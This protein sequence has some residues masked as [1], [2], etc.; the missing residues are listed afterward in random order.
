MAGKTA[1]SPYEALKQSLGD[2]PWYIAGDVGDVQ[3][4]T[5]FDKQDRRVASYNSII[6]LGYTLISIIKNTAKAAS[7]ILRQ[8][9]NRLKMKE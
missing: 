7:D 4:K 6:S 9:T 3:V 8:G 2:D 5:F 1:P